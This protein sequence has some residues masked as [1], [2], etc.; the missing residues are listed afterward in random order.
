MPWVHTHVQQPQEWAEEHYHI[1]YMYLLT[2]LPFSCTL[3][4]H[5]HEQTF[6]ICQQSFD[7]YY[8]YWV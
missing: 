3:H 8:L 7:F 2:V 1:T 6:T 5:V 4:V